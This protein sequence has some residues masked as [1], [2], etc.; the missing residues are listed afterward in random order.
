MTSPAEKRHDPVPGGLGALGTGPP[1]GSTAVTSA[2]RPVFEMEAIDHLQAVRTERIRAVLAPGNRSSCPSSPRAYALAHHLLEGA[3]AAARAR[4][5]TSFRWYQAAARRG[6]AAIDVDTPI[7]ATMVIA[8]RPD[9]MMRSHLSETAYHL[10]GPATTPARDRLRRLVADAFAQ[11]GATGFTRL[12]TRHAAII[13]LLF[14]R[15]FEA[16]LYS[17]SLTRL[18]G[19]IF[20][21]FTDEAAI[22]ARDVIHEAAHHWLNDALAA[23]G[24]AVPDDVRFYSPWRRTDR[25][26]FGFLH[27]CC[28]FPLTV[29]YA[30]AVRPRTSEP[31]RAFLDA[32]LRQQRPLLAGASDEFG[33]AVELV[34]DIDLRRRLVTIFEAARAP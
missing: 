24:A 13:C 23:T 4:D 7:G 26:A 34:P 14:H 2:L 19:T 17:W 31:V 16:T 21:D 28:A 30:Q 9:Q 32:Y 11:A 33:K 10:I 18:P 22:L 6:V 27:A 15:P 25:P 20:T 8:P 3:E 29:I 5:A 1:A 12:V